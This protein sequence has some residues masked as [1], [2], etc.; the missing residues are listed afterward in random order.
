MLG[1]VS[2]C[3]PGEPRIRPR[4]PPTSPFSEMTVTDTNVRTTPQEQKSWT[5]WVRTVV[6]VLVPERLTHSM[7]AWAPSPSG[8]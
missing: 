4:L 7:S 3:R 5:S 8:P 2:P 6:V 1:A